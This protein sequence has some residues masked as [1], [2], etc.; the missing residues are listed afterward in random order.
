MCVCVWGG[1]GC[2]L[3][4]NTF[5]HRNLTNFNEIKNTSK[6]INKTMYL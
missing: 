6:I 2:K 4:I 3:H 5:T 1:G